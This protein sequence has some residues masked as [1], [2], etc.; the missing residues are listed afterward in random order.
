M[1]LSSPRITGLR[2]D[3]PSSGVILSAEVEHGV[4][5]RAVS[6]DLAI[7]RSNTASN[8]E[9]L[10]Y[11]NTEGSKIRLPMNIMQA[12]DYLLRYRY[13]NGGDAAATH[14]VTVNG[15][16]QT[17]TLPPT[18][19]WG[20]FPEKS[21]VM[22]PATL[23]CGGNFIELEP[24]PNGNFAELDRIDFLR[25]IRDTIPANGFDNGIRVRL[26]KDDEFAI[27]DGGYAIFEN[28]VLDSLRDI[29]D[30]F[31]Q[32]KN[33]SSGKIVIRDGKKDGTAVFTCDLSNSSLMGGGWS[34]AK[35]SGDMGLRGIKD[36]YLTASGI[37]GEAILGNLIF[38]PMQVVCNQEPCGDPI[39]SSSE[40]APE[41]SSSTT[42]IA[43]REIRRDMRVPARK[44]Y[45]DLKGRS[46]DKQIRY[47]VMF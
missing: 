37:S 20:T 35:C 43:P 18:G 10:A 5:T 16:S 8:G 45:R 21:V 36:L 32:V 42:T 33:A 38:E 4:L 25:I 13:A 28:V 40:V 41:S 3:N 9:Y 44:G 34:A 26:T 27:K 15:K 19:S 31:L 22:V 6:G 39:S 46:F 29:G 30:V 2:W 17:V 7:T 12:G 1:I 14:K 23:K 11:V 24:S 47:R